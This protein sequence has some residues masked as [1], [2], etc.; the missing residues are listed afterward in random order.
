MRSGAP[1]LCSLGIKLL[2]KYVEEDTGDWPI[3]DDFLAARII[4]TTVHDI[5]EELLDLQN[6]IK[7]EPWFGAFYALMKEC[8]T[9]Y[10]M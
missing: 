4:S 5:D 8:E 7:A 6:M 2:D 9:L 3:A 1:G 10:Q